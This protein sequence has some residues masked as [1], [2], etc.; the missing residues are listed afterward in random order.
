MFTT[1]LSRS[2]F[3]AVVVQL[4]MLAVANFVEAN[5]DVYVCNP[6]KPYTSGPWMPVIRWVVDMRTSSSDFPEIANILTVRTEPFPERTV[7]HV[8]ATHIVH[9]LWDDMAP[10]ESHPIIRFRTPPVQNGLEL[11]NGFSFLQKGSKIILSPKACS[12][13]ISLE[14][15]PSGRRSIPWTKRVVDAIRREV[16]T[17]LKQLEIDITLN[18]R[19]AYDL[20]ISSLPAIDQDERNKRE[21]HFNHP[22]VDAHE[23]HFDTSSFLEAAAF[24]EYLDEYSDVKLSSNNGGGGEAMHTRESNDFDRAT[25]GDSD[26]VM[27]LPEAFA[28]STNVFSDFDDQTCFSA[29]FSKGESTRDSVWINSETQIHLKVRCA[30]GDCSSLPPGP[31][32]QHMKQKCKFSSDFISHFSKLIQRKVKGNEERISQ[33]GHLRYS[34]VLNHVSESLNKSLTENAWV[35]LSKAGRHQLVENIN[36]LT[37]D[38]VDD[39]DSSVPFPAERL[40][41]KHGKL[42]CFVFLISIYIYMCVCVCGWCWTPSGSRF[43]TLD[44]PLLDPQSVPHQLVR[45]TRNW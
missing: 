10:L 11:S 30:K 6:N 22:N 36:F 12:V 4:S 40:W 7:A 26:R 17:P 21:K 2:L 35:S 24:R 39:T 3:V 23:L 13:D 29:E 20:Y 14:V 5:G 8:P 43:L 16:E 25:E 19:F 9:A 15:E 32:S 18:D 31:S 38:R 28:T 44:I 42:F 37:D 45:P 27:Q 41:L 33:Y 1:I 34:P